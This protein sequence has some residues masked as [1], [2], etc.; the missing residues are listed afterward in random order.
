MEHE[1]VL[2][3]L[4]EFID[5]TLP[6]GDRRDVESHL[7]GCV[8]CAQEA[9][10]TRRLLERARTLPP[11]LLPERDLWP[12]I[13]AHLS[14]PA[15]EG[16]PHRSVPRWRTALAVAATLAVVLVG[17]RMVGRL[18]RGDRPFPGGAGLAATPPALSPSANRV[19]IALD[20]ETRAA[21]R[22]LAAALAGGTTLG[23]GEGAAINEGL[24]SLALAIAECRM[25]LTEFPDDPKLMLRLASYYRE[26]LE[27]L[28][29][30]TR[31]VR[32]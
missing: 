31:L 11:S 6:A 28:E 25:A 19:L 2:A 29:K 4:D 21:G 13:R 22:S 30:A 27:L 1:E 12:G 8:P 9:A 16:R 32:A 24:N 5:G 3:R 17:T 26:R 10:D 14:P 18:D 23:P 15:S 20:E 7:R